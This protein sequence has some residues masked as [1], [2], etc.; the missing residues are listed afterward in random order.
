MTF[1][2]RN[3]TYWRKEIAGHAIRFPDSLGDLSNESN[4]GVAAQ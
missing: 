3:F 1:A 4:E 2:R